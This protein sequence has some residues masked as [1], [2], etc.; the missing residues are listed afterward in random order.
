MT[1]QD[2]LPMFHMFIAVCRLIDYYRTLDPT[3]EEYNSDLARY[4][5]ELVEVWDKYP[6]MWDRQ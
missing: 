6:R 1:I 3:D 4:V 5:R 2:D